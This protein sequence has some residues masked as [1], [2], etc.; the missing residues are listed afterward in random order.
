MRTDQAITCQQ[1]KLGNAPDSTS[2]IQSKA[3]LHTPNIIA[4]FAS[5][6]FAQ[7]E[8]WQED[9]L[10]SETSDVT[11]HCLHSVNK[12]AITCCTSKHTA[13]SLPSDYWAYSLSVYLVSAS[14]HG[15]RDI[16]RTA[17][18]NLRAI[19]WR[20]KKERKKKACQ[21]ATKQKINWTVLVNY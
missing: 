2:A 6:L 4:L 14:Y 12:S 13:L 15:M 20:R 10:G 21:R 8:R 17:L 1:M 18:T 5:S 16:A 7:S 19:M 9:W 3:I 11:I